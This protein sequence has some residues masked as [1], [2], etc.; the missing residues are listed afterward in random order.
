VILKAREPA[1]ILVAIGKDDRWHLEYKRRWVIQYN[2]YLHDRDWGRMFV[3]LCPYFPFSARVCLNQ[4]QWLAN[5]LAADG[6]TFRL[7]GNAFLSC[8][9]PARL[10]A[11]ADSLAPRDLERCGQKWLQALTPFFTPTERRQAPV[12]TASSSRKSSTD[13]TRNDLRPQDHQTTSRQARDAHRGS[14]P[15]QS[16]HPELLPRRIH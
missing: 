9:D 7:C 8:S 13:E 15:P 11:L 1:R 5:R 12:N 6:L 14:R 2:F 4:H 3:R 16:G 10:Q